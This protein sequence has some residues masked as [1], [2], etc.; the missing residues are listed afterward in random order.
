MSYFGDIFGELTPY[1]TPV[2]NR[3]GFVD[4]N[5]RLV[6]NAIYDKVWEFE[7]AFAKVVFSGETIYIDREG[8]HY[9]KKPDIHG[10][11]YDDDDDDSYDD[12]DDDDDDDD[13]D[14]DDIDITDDDE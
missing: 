3:W 13:I 14:I 9:D 8:N 1:Q 10:G 7:G 12:D 2:N 11:D 5:D 4:E 6:I